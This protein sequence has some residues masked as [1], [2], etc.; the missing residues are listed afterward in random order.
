MYLPADEIGYPDFRDAVAS[1][2]RHLDLP[3]IT[4]GR[5]AHL[6]EQQGVIGSG[7][8]PRVVVPLRPQQ[9]NIRLRLRGATEANG[10]LHAHGR[11]I[12]DRA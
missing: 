8:C 10:L 9:G 11:A 5:L 2:Q 7:M 3:V 4:Q 1:I 6:Y 12:T